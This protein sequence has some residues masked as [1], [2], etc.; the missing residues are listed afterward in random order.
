LFTSSVISN[1]ESRDGYFRTSTNT[2][3]ENSHWKTSEAST[4][5]E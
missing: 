5:E 4:N 3:T 1:D 2:E